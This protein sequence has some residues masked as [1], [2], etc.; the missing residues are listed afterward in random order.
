M[1]GLVEF[2]VNSTAKGDQWN[3]SALQVVDVFHHI[4][5]VILSSDDFK[6]S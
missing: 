4:L 3:L 1:K 6:E 5:D 2:L